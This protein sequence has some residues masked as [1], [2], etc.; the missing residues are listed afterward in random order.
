MTGFWQ[1]ADVERSGRFRSCMLPEGTGPG[2]GTG[3]VVMDAALQLLGWNGSIPRL[4]RADGKVRARSVPARLNGDAGDKSRESLVV[5]AVDSASANGKDAGE[6]VQRKVY[7]RDWH[8][9]NWAQVNEGQDFLSLLGGLADYMVVRRTRFGFL[10]AFGFAVSAFWGFEA[11][12]AGVP[13][14]FGLAGFLVLGLGSG[15]G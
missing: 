7:L 4:F 5:P 11:L 3:Q 8:L 2:D 13:A 12:R 6:S 1:R 15:F 9:Y 14:A 10:D